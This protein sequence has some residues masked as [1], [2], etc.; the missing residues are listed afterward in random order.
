M[1]ITKL[2]LI[3][4][5]QKENIQ[6]CLRIEEVLIE[7]GLYSLPKLHLAEVL[8]EDNRSDF[9][10]LPIRGVLLLSV[11]INIYIQI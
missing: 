10:Y 4:L 5:L 6:M 7:L 8:K 11:C 9:F 1:N 3:N 2:I